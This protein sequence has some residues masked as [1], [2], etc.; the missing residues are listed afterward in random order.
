MLKFADTDFKGLSGL[1]DP[2]HRKIWSQQRRALETGE[3]QPDLDKRAKTLRERSYLRARRALEFGLRKA[4]LY[5]RG[6]ENAAALQRTDFD[7][8]LDGLPQTFDGY[9]I[10]HITDCHFDTNPGLLERLKGLLYKETVDLCVF[11]G[12]YQDNRKCPQAPLNAAAALV[13]LVGTFEQRDGALAVLGNHDSIDVVAPLEAQGIRVLANEWVSVPKGREQLV[14]T[15]LDDVHFFETP[16]AYKAL[17]AAPEGFRIVLVHSPDA[18]GPASLHG[19]DLYLCGHTHGGQIC[20]PNARPI[21]A[22]HRETSRLSS[23][24][25]AYGRMAGFTNRGAGTSMIPVRF[26]APPEVAFITLRCF[27]ERIA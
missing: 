11:T 26:N 13:E 9:R 3:V 19:H 12:D 14:V 2:D 17:A 5:D 25:W 18:A 10:A 21:I 16:M 6:V 15:G 7:M 22:N 20:L 24:R 4:K 8:L 1:I 23:G 27:K